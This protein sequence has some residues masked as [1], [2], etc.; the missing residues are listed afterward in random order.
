[1]SAILGLVHLP[2]L[3]KL[4]IN[5]LFSEQSLDCS[6]LT[7]F[8]VSPMQ[9]ASLRSIPHSPAP[10]G[11]NNS[12]L[13]KKVTF[14]RRNNSLKKIFFKISVYL[15]LYLCALSKGTPFPERIGR[16]IL[17]SH[18]VGP[19]KTIPPLSTK[20]RSASLFFC[21]LEFSHQRSFWGSVKQKL[22]LTNLYNQNCLRRQML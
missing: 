4:Q 17:S 6:T 16:S 12:L 3:D 21:L 5:M 2:F 11:I 18:L 15:Y 7:T 19:P 20:S 9:P 1:M 14:N 8:W 13:S 22:K 10:S